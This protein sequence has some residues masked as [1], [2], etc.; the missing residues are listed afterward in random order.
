M[1]VTSA[2]LAI[3]AMALSCRWATADPTQPTG[4]RMWSRGNIES[5][6]ATL[7]K[8]GVP[9]T[10]ILE[11]QT[12]G[13]LVLRRAVSGV[14][15]LHAKLNDFF[16]ILGGEAQIEVGGSATGVKTVARDEERGAK[17][18]GGTRYRVRHGDVLFVPANH[19]LQV[20]VAK[21]QVLRAIIIKTQ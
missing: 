2:T 4:A 14:P 19:W 16:V 5:L 9:Y 15:E 7:G 18:T 1:R 13:A 6:T 8:S 10:Q 12:Y 21:G 3:A 11:G 20:L 17:L